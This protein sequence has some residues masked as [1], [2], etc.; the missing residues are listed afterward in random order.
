[1]KGYATFK[2]HSL[3]AAGSG[4]SVYNKGIVQACIW[5]MGEYGQSLLSSHSCDKANRLARDGS[6]K[7]TPLKENEIVDALNELGR[8]Y[9]AT[10]GSNF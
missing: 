1:M 5:C 2:L 9:D 6:V 3:V 10:N 4:L 7:F 8:H